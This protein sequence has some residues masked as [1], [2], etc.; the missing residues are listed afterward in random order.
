MLFGCTVIKCADKVRENSLIILFFIFG[1]FSCPFLPHC[2]TVTLCALLLGR[3]LDYHSQLYEYSC[4]HVTLCQSCCDYYRIQ[5]MVFS[6]TS[7]SEIIFKMDI[8]SIIHGELFPWLNA[9]KARC[10][11][12]FQ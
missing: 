7:V 11:G 12:L 6:L 3:T 5:L 1:M 8:L 9:V 2:R 10:S 4:L